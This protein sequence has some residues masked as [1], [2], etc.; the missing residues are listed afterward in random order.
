MNKFLLPLVFAISSCSY[1]L[2]QIDQETI[3]RKNS[4][5]NFNSIQTFCPI[6]E[7][8]NFQAINTNKHSQEF[9]IDFIKSRDELDFLDHFALWTLLQATIRPEQSSPTAR[10]QLIMNFKDPAYFDFYSEDSSNQF[11]TLYGIEWILKKY[12]KKTKLEKYAQLLD[13]HFQNQMKVGTQLADYLFQN[14][15]ALLSHP[16]L[17]PYFIRGTEPLQEDERVPS[18]PYKKLVQHYRKFEKSQKI[19]VNIS[20]TSFQTQQGRSGECNYDFNLYDNS[21]FLIDKV[22]PQGNLFGFTNN[23]QSFFA[24]SSQKISEHAPVENFPIFKG[25]S[26][27]RSTGVCILKT[28]LGSIWTLSNN[29]RDP[30]QHLFH[31]IKYGLMSAN[32]GQEVD[33]LLKHSRHIFLNDPLRL[34]IESSR[35]RED[36]I[37]NLLKL[38]IPIYNAD[39]LGNVWA[40]SSLNKESRFIIDDRNPGAIT[41]K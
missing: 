38:N 27:V 30:G 34:V 5:D 37:E 26:K 35:S 40:F 20:L 25:H 13:Q 1:F 41:C 15:A 3:A 4:V 29:S 6:S 16:V 36:Q 24:A 11:P 23:R 31:L 8:V 32:N 12:G 7:R 28:E 19:T 39:L 21:I 10:L 33:K 2:K 17:G 18:V 14:K 9:F 22:T